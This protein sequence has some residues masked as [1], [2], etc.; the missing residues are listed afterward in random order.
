MREYDGFMADVWVLLVVVAF[1][2]LCV[3]LVWGCDRIIGPDELEDTDEAASDVHMANVRR[4]LEPEP[5]RPRYFLTEPGMG[6]RFEGADD[7]A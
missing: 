6:Y 4:K 1:F 3:A 7:P 2:G 5:S